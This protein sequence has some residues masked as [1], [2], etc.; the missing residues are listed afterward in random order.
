MRPSRSGSVVIWVEDAAEPRIH[1]VGLLMVGRS[2][3]CLAV[4]QDASDIVALCGFWFSGRFRRTRRGLRTEVR[5]LR[6]TR[7]GV[8]RLGWSGFFPGLPQV[9]GQGPSEAEWLCVVV[10]VADIVRVIVAMARSWT[11]PAPGPRMGTMVGPGPVDRGMAGSKI[12][13][14]SDRACPP[15]LVA[16]SADTTNYAFASRPLVV[17]I[18][19][20]SGVPAPGGPTGPRSLP[21]QA[22]ALGSPYLSGRLTARESIRGHGRPDPDE[23]N[24]PNSS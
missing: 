14:L 22:F 9:A 17:A 12:H 10:P 21:I 24:K 3:V 18:S 19:A 1:R 23:F 13:L 15:L 16:V 8:R 2:L 11:A 4:S 20:I 6:R 7:E 5:N